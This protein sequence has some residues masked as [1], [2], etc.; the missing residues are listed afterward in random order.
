MKIERPILAT[1]LLVTALLFSCSNDDIHPQKLEANKN[2][3]SE[4]EAKAIAQNI[5][6]SED[7]NNDQGILNTRSTPNASSKEIESILAAPTD[8]NQIAFY[9][10]TYKRGGFLILAGDKRSNPILAFSE[11]N[12][13]PL[14]SN[15][16]PSGLVDCLLGL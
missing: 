1:L 4:N 14:N 5:L 9:I 13:F 6:W 8:D 16:Y 2:E 7:L 11:N 12:T 15:I 10:I 3:V